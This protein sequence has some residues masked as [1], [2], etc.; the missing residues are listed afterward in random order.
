[1]FAIN[2][3]YLLYEN[4]MML[5]FSIIIKLIAHNTFTK[6]SMQF[7]LE[8]ARYISFYI[9]FKQTISVTC[10]KMVLLLL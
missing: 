7:R 3:S 10:S 6:M 5:C 2:I 9:K 1:M 4:R 8:E